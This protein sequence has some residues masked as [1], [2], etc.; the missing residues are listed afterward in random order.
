[1]LGG[2]F[3]DLMYFIFLFWG[4]FGAV[5]VV[6]FVVP[7]MLMVALTSWFGGACRHQ[8]PVVGVACSLV[9]SSKHCRRQHFPL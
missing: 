8:E 5:A 6:Q 3:G 7:S 1:M 4:T 2:V 9:H